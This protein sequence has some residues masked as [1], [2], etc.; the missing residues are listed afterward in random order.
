MNLLP[1]HSPNPPLGAVRA[2][3]SAHLMSQGSLTPVTQFVRMSHPDSVWSLHE[4]PATC[5]MTVPSTVP[6]CSRRRA[7]RTRRRVPRWR[8][9]RRIK[10]CTPSPPPGKPEESD[11][12][13][14][15]IAGALWFWLG[16]PLLGG[17]FCTIPFSSD[18]NGTKYFLSC[19]I[20]THG[21]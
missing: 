1:Y 12:L 3:C 2:W 5:Q 19:K 14:L 11:S 7:R 6:S 18:L 21:S 8:V 20:C 10:S 17:S 4:V 16:G 15:D 13:E 9:R